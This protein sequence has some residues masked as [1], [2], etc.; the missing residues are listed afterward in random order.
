MRNA[1]KGS[2]SNASGARRR[3][4]LVSS[5]GISARCGVTSSE[6]ATALKVPFDPLPYGPDLVGRSGLIVNALLASG[7]SAGFALKDEPENS[8]N[9]ISAEPDVRYRAVNIRFGSNLAF[10]AP[11]DADSF[12]RLSGH[13]PERRLL[14]GLWPT[15]PPQRGGQD[16]VCRELELGPSQNRITAT[17]PNASRRAA[18]A[19]GVIS[20]EVVSSPPT[21]AAEFIAACSIASAGSTPSASAAARV[22]V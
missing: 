1:A 15:R 20:P 10:A 7:P 5:T 17:S 13:C 6:M 19:S 9:R 3:R 2:K 8:G 22:D 18:I 11:V 21:T 14:R 12:E 16:S 4:R